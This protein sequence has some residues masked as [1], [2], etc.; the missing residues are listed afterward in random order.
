MFNNELSVLFEI[1]CRF[2]SDIRYISIFFLWCTLVGC[3][4]AGAQAVDC[5]TVDV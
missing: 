1:L 5:S 3:M 2:Y 4:V